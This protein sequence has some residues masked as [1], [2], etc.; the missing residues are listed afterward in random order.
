MASPI[1][2]SVATPSLSPPPEVAQPS[3][4][5]ENLDLEMKLQSSSIPAS[6][7]SSDASSYAEH[8]KYSLRNL[9][10]ISYLTFL[11]DRTP[12]MQAPADILLQTVDMWKEHIIAQFHGTL[13]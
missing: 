1:S 6:I 2:D 7:L 11:E 9:Q 10:K 8:F 12:V 4:R 13:S 5:S 3:S